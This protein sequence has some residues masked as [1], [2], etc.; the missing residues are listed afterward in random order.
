MQL[1]LSSFYDTMHKKSIKLTGFIVWEKLQGGS[2]SE[3]N[4]GALV[5]CP[6]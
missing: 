4:L 6:D 3:K 1:Q 2:S 5:F